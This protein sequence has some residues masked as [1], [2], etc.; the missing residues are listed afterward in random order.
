M[1]DRIYRIDADIY[2]NNTQAIFAVAPD[3]LAPALEKRLSG[4]RANGKTKLPGR[5]S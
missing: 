2:F 3:P 5:Y 1:P 4:D